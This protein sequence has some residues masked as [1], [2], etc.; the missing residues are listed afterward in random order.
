MCRNISV[1]NNNNQLL[2]KHEPLIKHKPEVIQPKNFAE[3]SRPSAR[4]HKLTYLKCHK[5]F[6]AE[7]IGIL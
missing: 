2:L 3:M 7:I 5:V 4:P 1:I 6:H